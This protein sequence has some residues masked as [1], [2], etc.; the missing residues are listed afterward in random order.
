MGRKERANAPLY[1]MNQM[2]PVDNSLDFFLSSRG[3]KQTAGTSQLSIELNLCADNLKQENY[4]KIFTV[5]Q[6]TMGAR[7][8]MISAC[9]VL[10]V[11]IFFAKGTLSQLCCRKLFQRTV[12][13]TLIDQAQ[14]V[15]Y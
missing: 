13:Y 4:E 3:Q 1:I 9:L 10:M 11:C 14:L 7:I 8:L 5:T 15:L 12:L 2:R 6:F